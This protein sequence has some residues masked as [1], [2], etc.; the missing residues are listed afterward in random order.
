VR[1]M[2]VTL[3]SGALFLIV[4]DTIA[5]TLFAPSEV[6]VGIL[7]VFVGGP[8]FLYLLRKGK[9]EYIL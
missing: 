5:R 6:P 1:L 2:P 4:T 7:M 9:R 8:F 3:L